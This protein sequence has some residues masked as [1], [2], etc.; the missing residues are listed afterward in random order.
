[1]SAR[2]AYPSRR[3][4]GH[5][6]GEGAFVGGA[7]P[8]PI[9]FHSNR[10]RTPAQAPGRAERQLSGRAGRSLVRRAHV[11][12][13]LRAASFPGP[14]LAAPQDRAAVRGVVVPLLSPTGGA[15]HPARPAFLKGTAT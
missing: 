5:R 2:L 6:R 7:L 4:A 9:T 3:R 15:S 11:L 10:S 14:C 13:A 8:A 1:M 12:Q